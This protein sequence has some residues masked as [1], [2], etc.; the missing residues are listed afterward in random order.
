VAVYDQL[1]LSHFPM[2]SAP[3]LGWSSTVTRL[4]LHLKWVKTSQNPFFQSAN[5]MKWRFP[6]NRGTPKSS[7][8][9]DH[10]SIETHGDLGNPHFKKLPNRIFASPHPVAEARMQPLHMRRW[11]NCCCTRGKGWTQASGRFTLGCWFH[12]GGGNFHSNDM[13]W[14]FW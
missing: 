3:A 9:V 10:L 13:S 1:F 6:K 8:S 14:P 12:W 11:N 7:K 4:A 2:V 5:P